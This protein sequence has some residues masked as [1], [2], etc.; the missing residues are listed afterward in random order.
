VVNKSSTI[1]S[2]YRNF[3]MELLAGESD[4]VAEVKE[5][6][7]TFKFDFSAVYWNSR[8]C[9]EH[10]RIIKLLPEGA[11]LFDV[12]A[13]VGPFSI[14]AAK[15]RRCR[16]F[17]NDLN[18]SSHQWLNENVKLNNVK[19]RVTTFNLDGRD[20]IKTELKKYLLDSTRYLFEIKLN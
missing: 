10:E 3:Q 16:V 19:E 8:L 18:P 12:F 15:V 1:D 6:R 17:S 14:P 13:G 4:Y 11:V 7:C 9:T 2:T 20:F 5:N